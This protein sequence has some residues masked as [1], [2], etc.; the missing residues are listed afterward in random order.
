MDSLVIQKWIYF[1]KNKN[2]SQK[3]KTVSKTLILHFH[4]NTSPL[5]L[6]EVKRLNFSRVS[7][8]LVLTTTFRAPLKS[9]TKMLRTFSSTTI[10]LSLSSYSVFLYNTEGQGRILERENLCSK[11]HDGI[12]RQK[13]RRSSFFP[14]SSKAAGHLFFQRGNFN[15]FIPMESPSIGSGEQMG[16]QWFP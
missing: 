2:S 9:S 13:R 14:L 6:V 4:F 12:C 3:Q 16:R 11:F 10:F 15:N 7:L 8:T 5:V 1:V